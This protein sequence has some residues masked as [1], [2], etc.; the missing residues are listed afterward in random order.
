MASTGAD[1]SPRRGAT[2][3]EPWLAQ[4]TPVRCVNPNSRHL[5]V[6]HGF[7]LQATAGLHGVLA[8]GHGHPCQS[9][10][11]V[12]TTFACVRQSRPLRQH[13]RSSPVARR[14]SLQRW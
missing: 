3:C 4:Q 2:G 9:A 6:I 7:S 5:A 10:A 12:Q 8:Q 11:G 13:A 14:T 1:A